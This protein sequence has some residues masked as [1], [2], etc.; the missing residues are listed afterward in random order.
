[1][2]T[3]FELLSEHACFG[4]T[5]RFYQHASNEIGLPM[6]FSVYLPPQASTGPVPALV[7]LA[8]LTCNEETFMTK[9]GAQRLAAEL[10]L[11]LIAPDTSPRGAK[12]PGESDSWDFGVG[13]GF[14]LDA[15][16]APW[17]AN[18]R[19]ESYLTAELLP[20]LTA[21]LPHDCLL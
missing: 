17:A 6:K 21:T 9:A 3:S 11:A 12:V 4:G 13:A 14:Y 10:G 1:M 18:Y 19:M 2:T 16:Q 7:Y 15:T 8:G 20:L 5:Q